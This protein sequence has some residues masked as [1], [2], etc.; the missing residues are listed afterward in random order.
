MIGLSDMNEITADCAIDG[1]QAHQILV[2]FENTY[3][4]SVIPPDTGDNARPALWAAM[5][6]ISAAGLAVIQKKRCF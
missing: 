1:K 5:M 6:V 4:V 2:E 3:F